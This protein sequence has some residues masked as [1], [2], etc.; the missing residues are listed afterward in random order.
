M[1]IEQLAE[2]ALAMVAPGKGIIA[3][4]EST[5]TIAKRFAG[6]GVENTEENR[7][8]YRELLL[9]TPKLSDY[10]SGAILFDET[11]RQST[12]DGVPFAKYMADNGIIPG[13]KVDKG[14]QALAGCPGELVTEGLDGLRARLE[15]YYKLGARFAKWRAVI[16]IG[17]DIPS[18][19]CIDANAHALAR[20]AALCQEQGLV[21]MV[22]P[23]VIMDGSH[24]ID[25]CYEVTEV[26]LRS[27]FAS[28]YEH[29]V[30]LEGTILKASMVLPGTTSG[31]DASVEEVAAATLQCLKSTVPATLPGIVF[32]SGGQSDEAATAHL[33]MMNRMGPNPWPLSFSYGRAMQQAA[34]KLWSQDIA[35]NVAA[36]QK[37]V[38]ERARD[39]GLAALGEWVKAA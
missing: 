34:L 36:A 23:E 7:R 13:I 11:L 14:A 17:E 19:T 24:D 35:A 37:T 27:L 16:N 2:T 28:L 38:F 29:N 18:G 20:Y 8:A 4:D 30:M 32:L 6:V 12:K 39:N 5:G 9:T 22:E 21:P 31:D 25:T 1:S 3:I 33:D 26:T 10:I 15:E